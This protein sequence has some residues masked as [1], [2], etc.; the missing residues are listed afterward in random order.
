MKRRYSKVPYIHQFFTHSQQFPSPRLTHVSLKLIS[1]KSRLI[2]FFLA[3]LVAGQIGS[4]PQ[5]ATNGLP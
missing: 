5:S 2:A 3:T 4:L 1:M